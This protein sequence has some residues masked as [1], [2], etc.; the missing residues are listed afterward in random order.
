[1]TSSGL[2]EIIISG[3]TCSIRRR[4]SRVCVGCIVVFNRGVPVCVDRNM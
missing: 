4:C 3:I 2:K 1:M